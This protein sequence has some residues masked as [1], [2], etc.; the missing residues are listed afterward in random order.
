MSNERVERMVGLIKK[1]LAEL[2]YQNAQPWT[3]YLP[4]VLFWCRK[5]GKHGNPSPF[6]LMYGTSL[7][8]SGDD[9]TCLATDPFNVSTREV[10]LMANLF[11]RARKCDEQRRQVGRRKEGKQVL[12]NVGDEV[13]VVKRSALGAM[14]MGFLQSKWYGSCRVVRALHPRY[15]LSTCNGKTTREP[16]H[17]RRLKQFVCRPLFLKR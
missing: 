13:L 6:Q 7:W 5:G 9:P 17:A 11:D 12:F 10:E 14:K 15:M 2:V 16:I 3:K 8:M 1:A 4:S